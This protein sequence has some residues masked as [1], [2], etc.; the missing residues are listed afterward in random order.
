MVDGVVRKEAARS[1]SAD[2]VNGDP[3]EDLRPAPITKIDNAITAVYDEAEAQKKKAPNLNQVVAPVQRK[4][5]EQGLSASKSTIQKLAADAK[6]AKRR[7]KGGPTLKNK[8]SD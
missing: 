8:K 2:G 5:R 6:H 3:A 1:V 4:L 7:R